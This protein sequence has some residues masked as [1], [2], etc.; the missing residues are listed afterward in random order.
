MQFA[1]KDWLFKIRV[2]HDGRYNRHIWFH[3]PEERDRAPYLDMAGNTDRALQAC[4]NLHNMLCLTEVSSAA[5]SVQASRSKPSAKSSAIFPRDQGK[6][7]NIVDF[8]DLH[9]PVDARD[10]KWGVLNILKLWKDVVIK[11]EFWR[12]VETIGKAIN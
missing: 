5:V 8:P 4:L 11:R 12:V 10:S 6:I 9:K 7:H 1:G 3:W 2:N